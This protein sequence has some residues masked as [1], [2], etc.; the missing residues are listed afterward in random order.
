MNEM[1]IKEKNHRLSRELY[2]GMVDVSFTV[3]VKDRF[4]A[5]TDHTM[6]EVFVD[7]LADLANTAK[8]TVPV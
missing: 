1:R 8:C 3:C 6:V 7:I 5:F 2:R 4:P